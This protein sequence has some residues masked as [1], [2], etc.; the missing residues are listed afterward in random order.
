MTRPGAPRSRRLAAGLLLAAVV[1]SMGAG[2]SE[3]QQDSAPPPFTGSAAA[4]G[5]RATLHVPG[6]AITDVP[7]DSGGPTAQAALDS[8]GQST[9]YA[10]LPDPGQFV[11]S[12]PGLGAGLLS[13]GAAGLPP[14]NF[15]APIPDY[16]LAVT[17]QYPSVNDRSVGEGPYRIEAH[18]RAE[19]SSSRALGG[20]QVSAAGNTALLQSS[21]SL[22]VDG[23]AV[24]ASAGTDFQGL[25]V[26]PLSIGRVRARAEVTMGAD[27]AVRPSSELA[28]DGLRIGG[29]G[30]GLGPD[31]ALSVLGAPVPLPVGSAIT[32]LL[33]GAGISL[34]VLPPPDT[35]EG[36]VISGAL[37]VTMRDLA[38]PNVGSGT[39]TLTIG[40][41][42][43]TLRAPAPFDP[44]APPA[45]DVPAAGTGAV[46]PEV[47]DAPGGIDL[48][49]AGV[50]PD[51]GPAEPSPPVQ[52]VGRT[53]AVQP[54]FD[55]GLPYLVM[56]V[57]AA[58]IV[59]LGQL[60]RLL[61][62][63]APWRT[64]DAG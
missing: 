59:V 7:L 6:F 26:G 64:S 15:P 11:V 25:T 16:P 27:G 39:L 28:V 44:A 30:V 14:I 49:P 19:S 23:A 34:E 35:A 2:T 1:G 43:A 47:G 36:T 51:L 29:V 52:T 60:T 32:D 56:V 3:A 37:R 18:S 62:V 48:P 40:A 42:S 8:F 45:T 54:D 41:A 21:T 31:G 55:L 63:R 57:A 50:T 46:L 10:A 53:I 38:I 17:T 61:G 13:G 12:L 5:V 20:L 4:F 9:A 22:E 58:A 33:A 24:S